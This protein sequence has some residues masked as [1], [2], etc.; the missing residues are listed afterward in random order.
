MVLNTALR[1]LHDA[2]AAQD[3]HQDVF[4]AIWRRWGRYDGQICWGPYLRRSTVRKALEHA[5]RAK[6]RPVTLAGETVPARGAGPDAHA[7]AEELQER[8]S[9]CLAQMPARQAEVFVLAR[10]E[11]LRHEEI[12]EILGCSRATV[13]VHLH[14]ALRRLGRKLRNNDT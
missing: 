12:A 8:L 11:G 14:R 7:A 6:R 3:V 1:I 13:R 4:L 5:R 9:Q 10:F 2:N